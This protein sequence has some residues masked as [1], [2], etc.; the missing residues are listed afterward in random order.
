MATTL[1]ARP[2]GND[3]LATVFAVLVRRR[4]DLSA[5]RIGK[6]VDVAVGQLD[7]QFHNILVME[8]VV[9]FDCGCVAKV[10]APHPGML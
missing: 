8:H 3:L 7:V 1:I 4:R 5:I 6:P 2:R 10:P 9:A